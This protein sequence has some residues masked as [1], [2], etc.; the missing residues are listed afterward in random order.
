MNKV[1]KVF[2]NAVILSTWNAHFHRSNKLILALHRY[3]KVGLIDWQHCG[4]VNIIAQFF[5]LKNLSQIKKNTN[6]IAYTSE[7]N[8]CLLGVLDLSFFIET[9]HQKLRVF[10]VSFVSGDYFVSLL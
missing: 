3:G 9:N 8:R 6:F 7:T 5:G 4:F 10:F 1:Q 2:F